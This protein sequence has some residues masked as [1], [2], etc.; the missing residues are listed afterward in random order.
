MKCVLVGSLWECLPV[1]RVHFCQYFY[2]LEY[3]VAW[4]VLPTQWRPGIRCH[5][6]IF[7]H[8][9]NSLPVLWTGTFVTS[10][11][12]YVYG[13]AVVVLEPATADVYGAV[14]VTATLPLGGIPVVTGTCRQNRNA[15]NREARISI[16]QP[17]C[18]SPW[19]TESNQSCAP[20]TIQQELL[21][22]PSAPSSPPPSP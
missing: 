11:H 16:L 19:I 13:A 6:T 7:W 12:S 1:R 18:S 8:T 21:S 3:F 15:N 4:F 5:V 10:F 2:N 17:V 14:Q 9:G 22:S 20:T